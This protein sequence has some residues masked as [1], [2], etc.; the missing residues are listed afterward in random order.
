M[1]V[2]AENMYSIVKHIYRKEQSAGKE[3]DENEIVIICAE[4]Y[5]DDNIINTSVMLKK[6]IV[7]LHRI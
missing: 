2:P 4:I 7:F 3:L 1:A 5:E 6:E